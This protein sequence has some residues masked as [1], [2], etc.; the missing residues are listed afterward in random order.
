MPAKY[1]FRKNIPL[2]IQVF[3]FLFLLSRGLYGQPLEDIAWQGIETKHVIIRYQSLEDLERFNA[4]VD[5]GPAKWVPDHLLSPKEFDDLMEVVTKKVDAIYKRVQDILDMHRRMEKV[6][7][8]LYHNRLQLHH[9]YRR[10]YNDTCHFRAWYTYEK[11]TICV[12]VDDLQAGMLAHELA[13]SV[14][15]H[16]LLIRPP[17]QTAEILA[18]YVDTHLSD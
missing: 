15:D 2:F 5:Y 7:M 1:S 8:M 18:R 10:I 11:N 14:I 16:Y 13:H 3:L 9:A 12:S 6:T 17:G 4:K